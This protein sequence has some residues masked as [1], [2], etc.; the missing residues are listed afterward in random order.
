MPKSLSRDTFNKWCQAHKQEL[1]AQAPSCPSS[2]PYQKVCVHVLGFPALLLG[3]NP[4]S[5]C[6]PHDHGGG[7]GM[8]YVVEGTLREVTLFPKHN[9]CTYQ[10]GESF[11]MDQNQVHYMEATTRSIT[12]HHYVDE[13]EYFYV[14]DPT[15]TKRWKVVSSAPAWYP[16]PEDVLQEEPW[17]PH[18]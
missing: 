9:D 6:L 15:G 3:W 2:L 7:S 17:Q 13:A 4:Q 14:Y 11:T 1:L 5:R 18:W 16:K 8:I 12:L 10:Q